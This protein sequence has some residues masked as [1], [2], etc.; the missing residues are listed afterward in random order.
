MIAPPLNATCSAS[1]SPTRAA[2]AVRTLA[3]TEMFMPITPQAP[4]S[5]AP[6]RNPKAVAQPSCGIKP[7]M[8]NRITP[9]MA[10]VVYWRRR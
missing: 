3:R 9:T 1:L 4:E 7:M 10:I 5:T 8:R 6:M 2:S